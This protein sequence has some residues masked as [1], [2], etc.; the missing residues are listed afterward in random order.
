V[1]TRVDAAS[2]EVTGSIRVG[3]DPTELAVSAEAVWV[4]DAAGSLYRV[5]A[6]TMAVEEFRIGAEVLGVAVDDG[7]GSVWIYAGD[8]VG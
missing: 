2:N 1:I 8:P 7:D 4:G 3:N 6:S 5:D